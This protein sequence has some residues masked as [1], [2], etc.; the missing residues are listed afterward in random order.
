MTFLSPSLPVPL[1]H[2]RVCTEVMHGESGGTAHPASL[3]ME[4]NPEMRLS[5]KAEESR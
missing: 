4:L 5:P 1:I 3:E 2:C